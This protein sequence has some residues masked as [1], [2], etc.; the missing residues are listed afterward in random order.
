MFTTMIKLFYFHCIRFIYLLLLCSVNENISNVLCNY[1][2]GES[3]WCSTQLR[4]ALQ[5]QSGYESGLEIE[6]H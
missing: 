4:A 2:H 3:Y 1:R 5:E 6:Q